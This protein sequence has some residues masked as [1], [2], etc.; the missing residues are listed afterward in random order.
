MPL[1]QAED[2]FTSMLFGVCLAVRRLLVFPELSKVSEE[3]NKPPQRLWGFVY[4]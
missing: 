2:L 1:G 3:K 4:D